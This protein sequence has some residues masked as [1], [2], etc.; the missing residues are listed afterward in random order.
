MQAL[1][2]SGTQ[3][4]TPTAQPVQNPVFSLWILG[5]KPVRNTTCWGEQTGKHPAT[6]IR[7]RFV[8][9]LTG[10]LTTMT[11]NSRPNVKAR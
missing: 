10:R 7:R 2:Q 1:P 5:G 11:E 8:P 3:R 6:L 4:L 9:A